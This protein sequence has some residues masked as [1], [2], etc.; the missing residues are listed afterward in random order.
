MS[1]EKASDVTG[2]LIAWQR[3]DREA[4]EKLMAAVY[5][6]LRVLARGYLR[7]ERPDHTL[8]SAALVHEAFL[9]LV[10]QKAAGWRNRSHFFGIAAQIMRRILVDHARRRA[11]GKRG[12]GAARLSLDEVPGVAERPGVDLVALDDA[13]GVLAGRDPRAARVVELRFFAGLTVRETAEVLA[14]SPATVKREW[15]AAKAWLFQQLRDEPSGDDS[16]RGG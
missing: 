13:L 6:E 3:G 2:L 8:P 12:G 4:L 9:R 7:Q 11:A 10:D 1:G 5:A 15:S 14:I 16:A